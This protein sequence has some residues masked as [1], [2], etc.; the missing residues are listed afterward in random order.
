MIA[1]VLR[2]QMGPRIVLPQ[3]D[4]VPDAAEP[5]R[6]QT[7]GAPGLWGIIIIQIRIHIFPMSYPIDVSIRGFT[8]GYSMEQCKTTKPKCNAV[9][10]RS[11]AGGCYHHVQPTVRVLS[12]SQRCAQVAESE[13]VDEK[14]RL[15]RAKPLLHKR[16]KN[17]Q[18]AYSHGLAYCIHLTPSK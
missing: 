17:D 5:G 14:L 3:D 15:G 6:S 13:D 2:E 12:A 16:C 7:S 18:S 1:D 11:N 10:A 9:R 4:D 8:K